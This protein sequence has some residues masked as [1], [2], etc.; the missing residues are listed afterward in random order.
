[1]LCG[2]AS[3]EAFQFRKAVPQK[4][5][6]MD[7]RPNQRHNGR[8]GGLLLKMGFLPHVK[9][10]GQKLG[11]FRH[12]TSTLCVSADF[13]SSPLSCPTLARFEPTA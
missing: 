12:A 13:M 5:P 6:S 8:T 4:T 1:M 3:S 7:L 11:S 2:A 10:F 9:H